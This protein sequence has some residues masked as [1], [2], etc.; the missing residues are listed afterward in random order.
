MAV[1]HHRAAEGTIP[2]EETQQHPEQRPFVGV[3]GVVPR[4]QELSRRAA[5]PTT[6]A[7]PWLL[8]SRSGACR[9]TRGTRGVSG[10]RVR[11]DLGRVPR[12]AT[13]AVKRNDGDPHLGISRRVA[14]S[15]P[16]EPVLN[17]GMTLDRINDRRSLLQQFDASRREYDRLRTV[18]STQ[19]CE[20]VLAHDS[21]TRTALLIWPRVGED[22]VA[23]RH[24]A[25]RQGRC[26]PG[27]W[28]RPGASS[29]RHLGRVRPA[30]HR[31]GH[32][33]G[34]EEPAH[35][36]RTAGFTSPTAALIEDLTQC[37]TRRHARAGAERDGL[38]PRNSRP[39]AAGMGL[40]VLQP[41]GAAR[42]KVVG[43]TD[44]IASGA[45]RPTPKA[46]DVLATAYHLLGIDHEQTVTDRQDRPVPLLPMVKSSAKRSDDSSP[47]PLEGR[48]ARLC[49]PGG[50]GLAAPYG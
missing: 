15:S 29:S 50:G 35:E 32:A 11:P 1:R 49:E 8:N 25:I 9:R 24:D 20:G 16:P 27:V 18:R 5:C 30:Q 19:N 43:K 41:P 6:S 31:M 26:K 48:V 12:A 2:I 14:S 36:D 4:P 34:P 3:G 28:S 21:P 45:D 22:A 7:P 17:D 37:G 46:K 33:R 23:L 39:T 10:G 40:R 42:G 44:R 47:S 13:Q 38:A